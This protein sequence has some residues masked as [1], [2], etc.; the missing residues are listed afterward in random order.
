[1]KRFIV[2]FVVTFVV[3]LVAQI[4]IAEAAPSSPK[5]V[6][7]L[8]REYHDGLRAPVRVPQEVTTTTTTTRPPT[9][10]IWPPPDNPT[11]TYPVPVTT[12]IVDA[13][14]TP[15][16][17]FH[18]R[19]GMRPDHNIELR[20]EW[21]G[22]PYPLDVRYITCFYADGV[23]LCGANPP[24]VYRN[25]GDFVVVLLPQYFATGVLPQ[26]L[27][28]SVQLRFADGQNSRIVSAPSV[29]QGTYK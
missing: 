15:P 9:T 17:P 7:V 22:K 3:M 25:E 18:L 13:S 28:L 21:V 23:S 24:Q 1:M 26:C 27:I 5:L 11:V 4:V 6:T 10:T 2:V 29:C 20:W 8:H 14:D 12:R 19:Y 16:A